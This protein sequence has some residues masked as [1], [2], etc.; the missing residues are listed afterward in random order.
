M[1][2]WKILPTMQRI[3]HRCGTVNTLAPAPVCITSH[4]SRPEGCTTVRKD[5]PGPVMESRATCG[6]VRW[7]GVYAA[8]ISSHLQMEVLVSAR[9]ETLE[10]TPTPLEQS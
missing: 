6:C 4:P 7:R 3:V 8:R 9:D 5:W 2:A 10:P 1:S